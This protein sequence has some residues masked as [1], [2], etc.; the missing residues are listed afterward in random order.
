ML[1]VDHGISNWLW[2]F[3]SPVR[4]VEGGCRNRIWVGSFPCQS[5]GGCTG[6]V[7]GANGRCYDAPTLA[8]VQEV[9]K[10]GL[11]TIPDGVTSEQIL[12]NIGAGYALTYLFGW[13]G[14]ILV[15]RL[16]LKIIGIDLPAEAAKLEGDDAIGGVMDLSRITRRTYRITKEK[17]T[18]LTMHEIMMSAGKDAAI[19]AIRRNGEFVKM[20]YE[21][22]LELGD[23]VLV[24]CKVAYLLDNTPDLGDEVVDEEGLSIPMCTAQ[25]V[26]SNK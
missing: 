13:V 24:I 19:I 8:A 12:T 10:S 22:R 1:G 25:I 4:W 16:M 17:I 26:V 11:A 21:T 23:E 5:S 7:S 14:L 18:H 2:E 6:F 3:D 9:I 20:K 15:I